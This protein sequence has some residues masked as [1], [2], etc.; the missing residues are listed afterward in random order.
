MT[1]EVPA[2]STFTLLQVPLGTTHFKFVSGGVVV[3]FD[4]RTFVGGVEESA[5]L[6]WD[7]NLS[8]LLTH[9]HSFPPNSTDPLF[10]M[11][12]ISFYQEVNGD[13]YALNDGSF[14]CRALVEVEAP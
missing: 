10:V 3:D 5:F 7:L 2:F 11:L 4:A 14:N 8:P 6:P 1:V 12:G 9:V 13:M